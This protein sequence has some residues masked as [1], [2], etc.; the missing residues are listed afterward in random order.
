[1]TKTLENMKSS[2][3]VEATILRTKDMS[4]R[5]LGEK[6]MSSR[7]AEGEA[8]AC[9]IASPG[10]CLKKWETLASQK[11]IDTANEEAIKM[12]NESI[13]LMDMSIVTGVLTR[14]EAQALLASS[15]HEGKQER[16]TLIQLMI[17]KPHFSCT[18]WSSGHPTEHSI[19]NAYVSAITN[20]RHFVYIENQVSKQA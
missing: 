3:W 17:A 18:K 12:A 9:S 10:I 14:T 20:A 1:M 4:K 6:N 15:L 11:A 7:R 5:N 13:A 8:M 16:L 19:A 2:A